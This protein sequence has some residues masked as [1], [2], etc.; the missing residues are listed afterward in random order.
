MVQ[1]EGQYKRTYEEK[2]DEFLSRL[3]VSFMLRKAM[4]VSTPTLVIAQLDGD[5]W[6]MNTSTSLNTVEMVFRFGEA[7]DE[8]TSDGRDLKTTV[9]QESLSRWVIEQV[10]QKSGQK[11]TRLIYD[12]T[13]RGIEVQMVCED[14]IS[15]QFF[16]R[17]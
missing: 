9:C 13:D 16:T 4:C 6:R 8:K 11:N 10:A 7:F 17:A 5:R 1:F 3:G 15:K 2:Y 14:V 12:V